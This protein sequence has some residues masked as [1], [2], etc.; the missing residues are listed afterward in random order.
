MSPT[1][2]APPAEGGPVA[3]APID[4]ALPEA[5]TDLPDADRSDAEPEA[6]TGRPAGRGT[7][8]ALAAGVAGLYG[9]LLGLGR[10]YDN[11]FWTHLATGRL[12]V[13]E[14]GI[15]RTD[16]YSFTAV[17]EPWVV[18]S[19]LASVVYA[20]AEDVGGFGAIRLVNGLLCAAIGVLVWRLTGR[21]DSLL[22]RIGV[23]GTVLVAGTELFY[24]RPLLY[25]MAGIALVL[26][27]GDGRLDPRWL[28]PVGWVWVNTHGS[29]PFAVVILVLLAVGTRLDRGRWGREPRVLAWMVGGLLVG[30][31]NPL[32]PRVLVFP[33]VLVR[34]TEAFSTIL[35]WR[36]PAYDAWHHY[37]VLALLMGAVLAVTRRPSWRDALLVTVFGALAMTSLRNNLVLVI[38]LAPVLAGSLP[39]WGPTVARASRPVLRPALALVPVLAVVFTATSM[40]QPHTNLSIYPEEEVLWMVDEGLWGPDSRVVAPDFVGNLRTAQDGR[41]AN[42][43]FDDRVDM[44]PLQV[45]HDNQTLLEAGPGWPEVLERRDATAV[46]WQRDSPLGGALERDDEWDLVHTSAQ[47]VVAVPAPAR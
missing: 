34:K 47:W 15:P 43:F 38:V 21:S 9:L 23:T 22:V 19:W 13:D 4:A 18:Q 39:A 31:I 28:V 6:A 8:G 2:E 11:S 3:S 29:F 27:A 10:L 33:L 12:I 36:P 46:L 42:V 35:E 24:G 20:L 16:P 30:G 45:V 14:G 5:D 25:G 7:A 40:A 17:G 37:A 1:T 44:Y 26:L 32:G 41:D